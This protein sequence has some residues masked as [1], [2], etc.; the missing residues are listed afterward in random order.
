M[1]FAGKKN[2]KNKKSTKARSV[3]LNVF[4]WLFAAAIFAVYEYGFFVLL[5]EEDATSL[6]PPMVA[7]A[8]MLMTVLTSV[9]YAKILLFDAKDY[10]LL[11]S[12]PLSG[13]TIVASKL[14]V[15]YTLDSVL[16]LVMLVPCGIFYAIFAKP[17]W[18]FYLYYAVMML[19]VT[20]IPI[21]LGTVISALVSLM[22]SRFRHAQAV[23][24][25]FYLLFFGGIMSISFLAGSSAGM[26][27]ETTVMIT[28]ILEG[29]LTSFTQ[30]YPPLG[31]F[32][33]AAMNGSLSS[34]L[35]FVGAS[36]LAFAIVSVVFGNY[37][38]KIHEIFRPRVFR[39]KYKAETKASGV[40]VTLIK[41]DL[42]HLFSSANLCMNQLTGLIMLVI[43]AI[44]FSI[45][46]FGASDEEMREI[47][48]IMFPFIF[49]MAAAMVCDTSTS[50]SLEGKTFPLLKS[51]PVSPKTILDSKLALHMLFCAP[52]ILVSGIFVSVMNHLPI[53]GVIATVVIPLCYAYSF[54]I[55]GLLINLKKYKFDWTSEITIAKNSLPM[56]LTMIGGMFLAILPMVLAIFLLVL[57]ENLAVVLGAFT[58]LSVACAII[59][60][61]VMNAVGEKWFLKIEY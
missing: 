34:A 46:D 39:T 61:L 7:L 40:F 6:F 60:Q 3:G 54:G 15:M 31:W 56:V 14:A 58:A 49:A 16:N 50:I 37:F 44:M 48:S 1:F 8:A 20:M 57:L 47:F 55:V 51:L 36:L 9:S 24:L 23:S 52:V 33:E 38:G 27:E 43:F 35:L 10:D 18:T 59:M 12:L 19:F 26:E 21:L 29:F 42:K 22:A 17:A 28:P 30:Y 13:K 2:P 25:V 41:K 11:Y 4:A 45:Q 32:R 53:I 5:A